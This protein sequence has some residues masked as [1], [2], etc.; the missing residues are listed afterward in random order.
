MPST[1]YKQSLETAVVS[2][3]AVIEFT[4]AQVVAESSTLL[5]GKNYPANHV[6]GVPEKNSAFKIVVYPL[7]PAIQ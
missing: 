2:S 5:C 6:I 1:S 4:P 7:P 3:S